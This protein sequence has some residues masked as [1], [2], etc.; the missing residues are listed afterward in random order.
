MK[1]LHIDL[2]SWKLIKKAYHLKGAS[3]RDLLSIIIS[4]QNTKRGMAMSNPTLA[5][6]CE[7][8]NR[9]I[10]NSKNQLIK[11]GLIDKSGI[12]VNGIIPYK[13]SKRCKHLMHLGCAPDAQ[14]TKGI[15]EEKKEVSFKDTLPP[16][17]E[18]FQWPEETY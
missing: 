16:R 6:I 8:S 18:E 9:S 12:K 10:T 15:V 5:D 4:F 2:H 17:V 14:D 1:Y 7:C 11:A 3:T 13:P